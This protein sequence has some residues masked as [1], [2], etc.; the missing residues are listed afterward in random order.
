MMINYFFIWAWMEVTK[1]TSSSSRN[2]CLE[3]YIFPISFL[4]NV[5]FFIQISYNLNR[6]RVRGHMNWIELRLLFCLRWTPHQHCYI[7]ICL[8][9]KYDNFSLNLITHPNKENISLIELNKWTGWERKISPKSKT[10]IHVFPP[11]LVPIPI[12]F[13]I[14]VSLY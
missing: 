11:I 3:I 4:L 10:E 1:E 5:F 14:L 12:S 7:K 2:I 6:I 9:N 13:P 8:V